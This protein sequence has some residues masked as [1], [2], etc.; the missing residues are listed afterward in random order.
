MPPSLGLRLTPISA[1]LVRHRVGLLVVL[2]VVVGLRALLPWVL[3]LVVE[4]QGEARLGRA[5]YVENVDLELL[6]GRLAVEGLS[7]GPIL[8]PGEEASEPDPRRTFLKLPRLEGNLQWLELLGG[9]VRLARIHLV[10]PEVKLLIDEDGRLVPILSPLLAEMEVSEEEMEDEE[11]GGGLPVA[12]DS[13]SI[14]G[15]AFVLLNLSRPDRKPFEL[16]F[17][18]LD[19]ADVAILDGELSIGEVGL[20]GPR[21]HVRRDIDLSAFQGEAQLAPEAGGVEIVAEVPIDGAEGVPD[22]VAEVRV[23]ET[24]P[25]ADA[26]G[27]ADEEQVAESGPPPP[28]A[29]TAPPSLRIAE[30]DIAAAELEI[31]VE[32]EPMIAT[33]RLKASDLNFAEPFPID[34]GLEIEGGSLEISG[35]AAT[36]PAFFEGRVGWKNLPMGRL[37]RAADVL[38]IDVESGASDGELQVYARV[39][40]SAAGEPPRVSVSGR[41]SS[42]GVQLGLSPEPGT[43][44]GVGWARLGIDLEALELEP[45]SAKPPSVVISELRLDAPVLRVART[46]VAAS[47]P[48]PA[49]PDADT[50]S[51]ASEEAAPDSPSVRVAVFELTNG[52]IDF[53]DG[54]VSPPHKTVMQPVVIS[55]RELR[56]PERRAASL[57]LSASAAEARLAL[58]LALDGQDG[59]GS[60]ELRDFRLQPW[61]PYLAE[62]SGYWV[63]DGEMTLTAKLG[64]SPQLIEVDG[65]VELLK[66][67][68]NEVQA[69]TFEEE[70]GLSLD[71]ALA[72]LRDPAGRVGFPIP[73]KLDESGAG[74]SMAPIVAAVLRQ[75]IVGALTSPLKGLGMGLEMVM[76]GGDRRAKGMQL[77]PISLAPGAIQ[78]GSSDEAALDAASKILDERPGLSL[79]LHGTSGPADDRA[80]AERI[81][82]EAVQEDQDLPPVSAGFLQKRR[83]VGALKD[84]GRGQDDD[85]D[86]EDAALLESWIASVEVTDGR[87][88]GLSR[89]RAE[90][91]RTLL[92][93]ERG[94]PE[95]RV[96]AG[97]PLPG[98]PGVL[99][100][101]VSSRQ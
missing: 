67:S 21:L 23:G 20:E 68:I 7:V 51:E 79:V 32:D 19:V 17:E 60:L 42:R 18:T 50:E 63:E 78:P 37:A 3:V 40:E 93:G 98:E 57:E 2:G 90:A 41:V 97:D 61:S 76:G 9:R 43:S 34:F 101:L 27:R 75:A 92:V 100:Q 46:K 77:T 88:E 91:A 30:I 84:R 52:E 29:P 38:P 28:P 81:L 48:A 55:A 96:A 26:A 10:D 72:L 11:S 70:F 5:V 13:V 58:Q 80:L 71:L 87:R 59:N 73:V 99:I 74:A 35:Q 14:E 36:G 12:L 86:A 25:A 83:L 6:A 54:T 94:V 53:S 95:G 31:V 49:E 62:A 33:L 16:S 69:G 4:S 56:W 47:E 39:A 8:R 1:W 85:L 82:I 24:P 44:A 89:E 45:G 66:L 15:A 65:D 64:M 22:A